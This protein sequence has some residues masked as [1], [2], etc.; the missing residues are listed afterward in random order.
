MTV[1]HSLASRLW[2]R[3]TTAAFAVLAIVGTAA[4]PVAAQ[5]VSGKE[6]DFA[7]AGFV[8][9]PASTSAQRAMLARLPKKKLLQRVNGDVV[10]YVYADPK[11][12]NCMY[13]GDQQAYQS[14]QQQRQRQGLV[15]AAQDVA[16]DYS[17]P[18]WNWGAWGGGFGGG[19][20]YGGLGW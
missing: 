20:R 2:S 4:V 15:D 9:K 13:V 18:A 11:G 7:A 16:D 5:H 19:F 14:Y 3:R 17:D 6:S 10:H 1:Q 8:V 12:C